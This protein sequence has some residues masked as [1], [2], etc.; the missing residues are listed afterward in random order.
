M[1]TPENPQNTLPQNTP[2]LT[3][4]EIWEG[5]SGNAMVKQTKGV[6]KQR[7]GDKAGLPCEAPGCTRTE[8]SRWLSAGRCCTAVKCQ[9][10][11]SVGKGKAAAVAAAAEVA[12]AAASPAAQAA[13]ARLEPGAT[14]RELPPWS[15]AYLDEI[16]HESLRD[17]GTLVEKYPYTVLNVR[18]DEWEGTLD[19]S[20]LIVGTFELDKAIASAAA[21]RA[22]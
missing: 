11:F 1:N 5:C 12:A 22:G 4:W 18:R 19:W 9:E 14:L 3:F 20:F 6:M 15:S 7:P 21:S 16:E 8:C 13:C 10:H 2:V 17:I